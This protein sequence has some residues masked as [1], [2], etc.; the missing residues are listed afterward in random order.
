LLTRYF[1][2]N[3]TLGPLLKKMPASHDI[4]G[5]MATEKLFEGCAADKVQMLTA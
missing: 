5:E 3:R 1:V 2:P 4:L